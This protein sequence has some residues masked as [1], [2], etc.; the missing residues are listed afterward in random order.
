MR[1]KNA[2]RKMFTDGGRNL[3]LLG[4]ASIVVSMA[5]IGVSLAIYHN[6]GDIY[7]DRSRPGYLPDEQEIEEEDKQEQYIFDKTGKITMEVI[8]EYL[9]RLQVDVRAIDAYEKPFDEN[10][11]SDEKLGIPVIEQSEENGT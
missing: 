4:V 5:T 9:E 6:S 3:V 2:K 8:D 1:G 11:L 10:V 7:L